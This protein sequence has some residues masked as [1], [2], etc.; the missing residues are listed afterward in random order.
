[1]INPRILCLILCALAP[2]LWAQSTGTPRNPFWPIGY[3]QKQDKP[4]PANT[5]VAKKATTDKKQVTEAAKKAFIKK[6][7]KCLR[8]SGVVI[9]EED[10]GSK[11]RT[12]LVNGKALREGQYIRWDC[13]GHTIVGKVTQHKTGQ[14][15]VQ[16]CS[17]SKSN[18]K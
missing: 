15:Y 11:T 3:S 16:Y 7:L 4:A 10:N 2:I 13:E 1:M 6:A 17:H 12:L 9:H 14:L 8:I 18:K 5:P